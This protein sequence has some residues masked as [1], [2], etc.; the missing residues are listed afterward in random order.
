MLVAGLILKVR[1]DCE[2]VAMTCDMGRK[3]I[4]AS[5]VQGLWLRR[6]QAPERNLEKGTK[7]CAGSDRMLSTLA[8]GIA[9]FWPCNE[10]IILGHGS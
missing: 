4:E 9:P 3:V 10:K 6:I 1:D 7:R 8:V 5:K 2:K